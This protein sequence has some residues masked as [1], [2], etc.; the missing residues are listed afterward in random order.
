MNQ[1][2]ATFRRKVAITIFF[3]LM[4]MIMLAMAYTQTI[5]LHLRKTEIIAL[6]WL[7]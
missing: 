3:T 4:V 2:G 5:L 1:N 7:L 6:K